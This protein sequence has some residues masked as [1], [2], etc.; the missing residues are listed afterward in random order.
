MLRGAIPRHAQP[1]RMAATG[2]RTI[3]LLPAGS[4]AGDL[5]VSTLVLR[6]GHPHPTPDGIQ[7]TERILAEVD[8]LGRGQR[9]LV[10]LSG[11]ASALLEAPAPGLSCTELTLAHRALVASGLAIRSIN[12][13]RGCLSAVKGGRLSR[14]AHPAV[15]TTLAISDVEGDDAAVIGGGPTVPS[16]RSHAATCGEALDLVRAAGIELPAAALRVLEEGASAQGPD[17]GAA[18]AGHATGSATRPAAGEPAIDYTVIASI[19]DAVAG[20]RAELERRGYHVVAGTGVAGAYLRGETRDA[21]GLIVRTLAGQGA[22]RRDG[23]AGRHGRDGEPGHV[24]ADSPIAA[25]FGGETTVAVTT[26]TPGRGGRNLDMAARVALAIRGCDGVAV[27]AAGTD[28]C[29]GS[30]RAAG[31]VVDGGTATRAESGGRALE[32]ALAAFDSEA[33]LEAAG[34]LFVTGPTGTNVGDLVVAV[35]R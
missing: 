24:V 14:R 17:D 1:A 31:A 22:H 4:Q 27:L 34:D 28:G 29:D 25:V 30:S 7:A 8:R 33:A 9:L 11:G 6:G 15:T 20:A 26:A 19:A 13:V 32:A 18:T 35:A 21:A 12:L 23:E 2:A 10:L 16:R 3:V 5:P